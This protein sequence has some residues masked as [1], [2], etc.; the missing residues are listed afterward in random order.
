MTGRLIL[1]IITLIFIL[2]MNAKDFNNLNKGV[3]SYIQAESGLLDTIIA[4]GFTPVLLG[5]NLEDGWVWVII[6]ILETVYISI[7][8]FFYLKIRKKQEEELNELYEEIRKKRKFESVIKEE[9]S[10]NEKIK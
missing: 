10:Q 1:F 5:L 9:E 6:F 2:V 3:T 4:L 7:Y 8:T